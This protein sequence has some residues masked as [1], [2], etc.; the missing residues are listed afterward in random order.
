M[1]SALRNKKSLLVARLLKPTSV[2]M[3]STM[4]VNG[5][6][7]LYNLWLGRTLGP[8]D[9]SEVGLLLTFLL[10]LSFAGMTYQLVAS[11]FVIDLDDH[12]VK[13]FSY[14][15][16]KRSWQLGI[17][18]T[19]LIIAFSGGITEFFHLKSRWSVMLFALSIPVYFLLSSERG[20]LQGRQSFIGLSLSYQLEIWSKFIATLLLLY[21]FRDQAG[22]AISLSMLLSIFISK[23]FRNT[24]FEISSGSAV[25]IPKHIIKK[26][27]MFAGFT[28]SYEL[29]QITINYGDLLMVKHYFDPETAGL[30]TAVALIGRIIYFITWMMVMVLIPTILQKR[31]DGFPYKKIMFSYLTV[32]TT[33][34]LLIITFS[35]GFPELTIRLLFGDAFIPFAPILWKYALATSLFALANLFIYYFISIEYYR[36]VYL[37]GIFAVIQ[38]GLYVLFHNSIDQIIEIQI[39]MMGTLFVIQLGIFIFKK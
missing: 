4:I 5:G 17:V 21:L 19:V 26:I 22:I 10:I 33:A 34:S 20:L 30:Y 1:Y 8:A 9:F 24:E 12:L 38:L 2:F 28:L 3:I 14:L 35:A 18:F 36:S 13:P 25:K 37:A 16:K 31:K 29:I 39:I 7:Y 11:K 6:N 15:L 32:I 23:Y 27:L